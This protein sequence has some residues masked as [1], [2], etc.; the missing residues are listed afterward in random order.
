MTSGLPSTVS[1]IPCECDI[2]QKKDLTLILTTHSH[3]T[4]HHLFGVFGASGVRKADERA[5]DGNPGAPLELEGKGN[6]WTKHR[7]A[8]RSDA[9]SLSC[10]LSSDCTTVT[11]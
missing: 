7:D 8:A 6:E 10:L 3:E 11:H 5:V 4:A 1:L 9:G 2:R